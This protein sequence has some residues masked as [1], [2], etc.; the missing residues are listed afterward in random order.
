MSA[1]WRRAI[2][3]CPQLGPAAGTAD[4]LCASRPAGTCWLQATVAPRPEHL[5]RRRC[6]RSPFAC[7]LPADPDLLQCAPFPIVRPRRGHRG[8]TPP[9]R[10]RPARRGLPPPFRCRRG[11]FLQHE[12]AAAWPLAPFVAIYKAAPPCAPPHPSLPR[13]EG[14]RRKQIAL[15]RV[16][17]TAAP[18][19]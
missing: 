7:L 4:V 2:G 5:R 13:R 12:R 10:W 18:F 8:F 16:P 3:V 15:V 11:A 9:A 17:L 19:F 6:S 1:A 14:Q